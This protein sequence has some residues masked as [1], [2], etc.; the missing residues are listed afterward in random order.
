MNIG[1]IIEHNNTRGV[2]IWHDDKHVK[3]ST[4]TSQELKLVPLSQI[5]VTTE[6]YFDSPQQQ[7]VLRQL[8]TVRQ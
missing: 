4:I 5:I 1:Q 8:A 7:K 2:V 6:N 3:Y